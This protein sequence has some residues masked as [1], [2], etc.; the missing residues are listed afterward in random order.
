M[1][2]QPPVKLFDRHQTMGPNTQIINYRVSPD[3]MWCILGG[4]STGVGGRVNGNMQ[5]YNVER[6]LSQPL[7]GHAAAF[8]T[9][10]IPGR[11]DPAQL[12]V[13]HEK[14]AK[15]PAEPPWFY[16]KEIGRDPNRGPPFAVAPVSIPVPADGVGDFPVSMAIDQKHEIAFMFTRKGYV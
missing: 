16:I 2:G 1:F 3:G 9:I 10:K 7:Q 8:C 5:L 4:I 6:E 15:N 12:I 13:F 11:E 14:K